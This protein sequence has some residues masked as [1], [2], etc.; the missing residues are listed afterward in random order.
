MMSMATNLIGIHMRCIYSTV[1]SK[2]GLG[3]IISSCGGLAFFFFY[4]ITDSSSLQM[5][6]S[7]WRRNN[8]LVWRGSKDQNSQ[9]ETT[10]RASTC[11]L[12][13]T[14]PGGASQNGTERSRALRCELLT[15]RLIPSHLQNRACV[16]LT[17]EI[18][19]LN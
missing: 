10:Q 9:E 6:C 18:S 11:C 3:E 5:C 2:I 14:T 7:R 19:A 15:R 1:G 16:A 4:S 17:V 12:G 8:Y 13:I